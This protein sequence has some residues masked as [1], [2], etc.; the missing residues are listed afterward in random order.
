MKHNEPFIDDLQRLLTE[1][2]EFERPDV[3]REG[4]A[5]LFIEGINLLLQNSPNKENFKNKTIELFTVI[6]DRW[7]ATEPQG[8][9]TP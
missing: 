7:I 2:F 1:H 5:S 9:T 3:C 6:L 4:A 8:P